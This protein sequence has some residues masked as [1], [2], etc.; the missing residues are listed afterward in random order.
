M[1]SEF[2][3]R[4][5]NIFRKALLLVEMVLSFYFVAQSG[6][7]SGLLC[8]AFVVLVYTTWMLRSEIRRK[9][10]YGIVGIVGFVFL[11]SVAVKMIPANTLY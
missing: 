10:L 8:I 6:S 1:V 4:K 11:L 3:L 2:L 7:R 5:N 9:P